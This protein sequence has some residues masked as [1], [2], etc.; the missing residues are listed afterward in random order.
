MQ[1]SPTLDLLVK[2]HGWILTAAVTAKYLGFPSTDAL[3]VARKRGQLPVRMFHVDGRSGWFSAS[4]DVANWLDEMMSEARTANA[5]P[6]TANEKATA[7]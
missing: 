2:A 4:R 1:E 6:N 3:R 5:K 7:S